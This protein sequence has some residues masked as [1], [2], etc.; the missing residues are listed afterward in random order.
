LIGFPLSGTNPA[1]KGE[2]WSVMQKAGFISLG[3]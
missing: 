3:G 1:G 2:R